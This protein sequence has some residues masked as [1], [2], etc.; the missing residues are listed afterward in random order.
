[1]INSHISSVIP[2]LENHYVIYSFIVE[3]HGLYLKALSE[4]I[5]KMIVEPLIPYPVQTSFLRGEWTNN[6][7]FASPL[8]L[9]CMSKRSC[10][11]LFRDPIPF[12]SGKK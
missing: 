1:M 4:T 6:G 5:S 10:E 11:L 9:P 12:I 8:V 2:S 3:S 7:C